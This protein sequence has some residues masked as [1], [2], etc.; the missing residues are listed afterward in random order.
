MKIVDNLPKGLSFPI[1]ASRTYLESQSGADRVGYFIDNEMIL[2]FVIRKKGL[3]RW[4]QLYTEVLNCYT[5]EQE[6]LFLN[7]C[8][9]TIKSHFRIS[10]V[11][12]SNTSVFK[13]YPDGSEFCKWGTYKVD[14]S[15][16]IDSLF[17]NLH[18]KHRNAI[19]RA[20][21]LDLEVCNGKEHAKEAIS[22][23]NDTYARQGSKYSFGEAFIKN[24]SKLGDNVDWW[25]VRDKSGI[26][27]G[28]AVFLWSKESSCY[29]LHGGS[30]SHTA[31]G[32]MNL[33]IWRAM[34]EMKNRGVNF[35]DFVGARITTVEGSKLEGIQRFKS[36]FGSTMYQGYMFRYIVSPSYYFLYNTAL[37]LFYRFHGIHGSYD[38]IQQ[39]REKGN[40]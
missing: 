10:H 23:M 3:L 1:I 34:L 37:H 35:F 20:Q 31:P 19:R 4:M 21:S 12:S 13:S 11:M 2:P 28:S 7:D 22:I 29:Y 6:R 32:A 9:S 26:I 36:R 24:L 33:L 5:P 25:I 8:I 40:F 18:S 30:C 15:L 38:I 14:L 17:S 16:D 27:H 39:E